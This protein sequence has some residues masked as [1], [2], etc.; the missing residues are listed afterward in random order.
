MRRLAVAVL[1]AAWTAAAP[2]QVAILQI[3]V[4]EGEGGVHAA[5]ARLARPIVV[6]VGDDTG[7]PVAGVSVSFHL[8]EDGP[9]GTFPNGLRTEVTTT[10]AGGR[11]AI[12]GLTFNRAPGR[13]AIRIIAVKEQT[14]A[15]T[16]SYQYIAEP[17]AGPAARAV[18]SRRS[19]WVAVAVVAGIT[20]A[21]IVVGVTHGQGGTAVAPPLS[22]P[23]VQPPTPAAAPVMGTP[24]ITVGKP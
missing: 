2:A 13:F 7:R 22:P 17:K 16:F 12:R 11:A 23:P 19:W 3:K 20:A 21:G 4:V 9:G 5:G 18:K 1:A 14:R 8:P 15:G 10:D 24:V 6:E